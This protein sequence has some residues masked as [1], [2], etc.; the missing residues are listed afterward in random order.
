MVRDLAILYELSLSIGQTLDLEENCARFLQVLLRR[1]TFVYGAVWL[2]AAPGERARLI[3]GYPRY[4]VETVVSALPSLAARCL[5]TGREIAVTEEQEGFAALVQERRLTGGC[6]LLY[7]LGEQGLI[8]L[9]SPRRE[10]AADASL[11]RMLSQVIGKFAVSVQ[12]CLLYGRLREE[13]EER[14]QAEEEVRWLNNQLEQR[15]S[16]RTAQ[17]LAVN[18]Q[19]RQE[20]AERRRAE[21]RLRHHSEHDALTGLAN[22][23]RFEALRRELSAADCGVLGVLAV[24]VNDLKVVN[25][26]QG[27]EAGDALLRQVGEVLRRTLSRGTLVARTGGDEFIALYRQGAAADLAQE[28]AALR[29]AC[30]AAGLSASVGSAWGRL[31]E[32]PC[33]ELLCQA[34]NAMYADKC[35]FASSRRQVGL[36]RLRRMLEVGDAWDEAHVRRL[37]G[38][39]LRFGAYLALEASGETLRLLAQFHDIGTLVLPEAV[40]SKAA[41]YSAEERLQ[42]RRHAE[43]GYRLAQLLPELAPLAEAIRHHHER[44]DGSGYP[45]G[46]EGEQIPLLSRV[47]AV[48]DA[49]ETMTGNRRYGPSVSRQE[50]IGRA[51]V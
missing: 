24:D 21:E 29:A 28:E 6:Y 40:V 9:Y 22:R 18:A 20:I 36:T 30:G 8:K 7:P 10:L 4:H 39:L 48:A 2:Q 32:V 37:E 43:N 11:R 3:Y 23:S 46:L 50:E 15:V 31:Q 35:R 33:Q 38:L 1:K 5:A 27:H 49:Y 45:C 16:K 13:A 17:L 51:H 14:R 19:L 34:D 12:A 26:L 42:M 41:S 44:W 25:D 47:L